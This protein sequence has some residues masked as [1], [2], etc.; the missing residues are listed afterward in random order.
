[1][2]HCM[3]F[4]TDC[5]SEPASETSVEDELFHVEL[6]PSAS[7]DVLI[8]AGMINLDAA[9][10]LYDV[11]LQ[12]LASGSVAAID[13]SQATHLSA[14]ALHVLLALRTAVHAR[15]FVLSG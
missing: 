13:W 8:L 3:T 1:M 4:T 5:E 15:G 14:R 12:A 7:C 2:T 6:R 11:A 9:R 10:Q